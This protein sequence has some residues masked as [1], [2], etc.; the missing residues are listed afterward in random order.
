MK[1]MHGDVRGVFQPFGGYVDQIVFENGSPC[2]SAIVYWVDVDEVTFRTA[3]EAMEKAMIRLWNRTWIV[4]LD[5]CSPDLTVLAFNL[6]LTGTPWTDYMADHSSPVYMEIEQQIEADFAELGGQLRTL[7]LGDNNGCIRV[8]VDWEAWQPEEIIELTSRVTNSG[9][10]INN[11]TVSVSTRPC[12]TSDAAIDECPPVPK[13]TS[14]ICIMGCDDDNPEMAC[15]EGYK[16]CSNGCGRVC[17]RVGYKIRV[18]VYV[19][20]DGMLPPSVAE[21]PLSSITTSVYNMVKE[22]FNTAESSPVLSV[23]VSNLGNHMIMGRD[24]TQMNL[25]MYLSEDLS[26]N[27]LKAGIHKIEGMTL[28]FGAAQIRIAHAEFF[29]HSLHDFR[30]CGGAMC[31]GI[32]KHQ[33]TGADY[34]SCGAGRLGPSCSVFDCRKDP[35]SEVAIGVQE[36]HCVQGQCV[37]Y[38]G[39]NGECNCTE[40]YYGDQCDVNVCNMLNNACGSHGKCVGLVDQGKLC[41]CDQGW[42]GIFCDVNSSDDMKMSNC[43]MERRLM[44]FVHQ[45]VYSTSLSPKLNVFMS[46]LLKRMQADMYSIPFCWA[47]GSGK[48]GEYHSTCHYSSDTLMSVTCECLNSLKQ[49]S[50]YTYF[51]PGDCRMFSSGVFWNRDYFHILNM[52]WTEDLLLDDSEIYM[53]IKDQIAGAATSLGGGVSIINFMRKEEGC[54]IAQV[55][56]YSS[57]LADEGKLAE[58]LEANGITVMGQRKRIS[59]NDCTGDNT[60]REYVATFTFYVSG[61]P[62]SIDMYDNSSMVYRMAKMAVE[63]A[64]SNLGGKLRTLYLSESDHGCVMFFVEWESTS[65]FNSFTVMENLKANGLNSGSQTFPVKLRPCQA[66][67]SDNACPAVNPGSIGICA[68]MCGDTNPCQEG[69]NCCSNGCGH[70]CIRAD[71]KVKVLAMVTVDMDMTMHEDLRNRS[72]PLYRAMKEGINMKI[73]E[74]FNSSIVVSAEL[75]GISLSSFKLPFLLFLPIVLQTIPSPSIIHSP[76]NCAFTFYTSSSLKLPFS[77]LSRVSFKLLLL[78]HH[79]ILM[80]T[81]SSPLPILLQTASSPLPIFLQTGPST[82][83]ILLQTASSPLPILLQTASSPLPILLQTAPSTLPILLQTAPSTL[84]ILFQTA[85]S[86]LPILLQTAPSTLPILLQ[87]AS[88]PLPILLQTALYTLP[89]LLQTAPSTLPILLQSAPSTLLILLQ[90][91][92]STLLILL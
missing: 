70:V 77:H 53:A 22:L 1:Q 44:Q 6:Y 10:T 58:A 88:S 40:G 30:S 45:Q 91:A 71:F 76:D 13:G 64:F 51:G 75:K 55:D 86:T 28:T 82:F 50:G 3:M 33:T 26:N 59:R 34:C 36:N 74:T 72:S 63:A 89:I 29:N 17:V 14:G 9:F 47:E 8:F 32:C 46:T 87:T 81:A 19:V 73:E 2:V 68:E 78:H 69:Y 38:P 66:D 7:E 42:S 80:Q 4:S 27:E 56:W 15:E 41:E 84:L 31:H 90:T 21:S 5:G 79:H 48:D 49:P 23:E 25:N 83:P 43:N 52:T 18:T 12:T 60:V 61:L 20:A 16:C 65:I 35:F 57:S 54:V 11:Q 85:P 39:E 24:S 92:P 62:T 37:V 67:T